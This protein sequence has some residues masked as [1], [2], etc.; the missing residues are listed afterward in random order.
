MTTTDCLCD[1]G[2]GGMYG[3]DEYY[4][5]AHSTAYTLNSS[6]ADH[7][8]GQNYDAAHEIYYIS[9]IFMK[10]DT[11]VIPD[12]DTITQ[13]N[14]KLVATHN[15]SDTDFDVVIKKADWSAYDPASEANK[16]SIYDLI[17]SASSDTNIWRNT[18]G[19]SINTQ[20][21]SG[22]LD[23]ARINKLGYTYYG[24]ISSRDI[25]SS[26]PVMDV[27][28]A[29]RIASQENATTGYR[30]ILTITHIPVGGHPVAVSPFFNI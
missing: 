8:L 1:S 28:E 10:F 27:G 9:R 19:I 30:P 17:L 15:Y 16:D 23:A 5:T 20:Y 22:N 4:A 25:S 18:S 3:A 13:V 29:V 12:S 21:T 26:T 14:M 2:D 6:G 11:S 24:L 7:Q